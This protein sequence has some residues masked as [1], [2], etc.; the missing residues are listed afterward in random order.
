MASRVSRRVYAPT[1]ED[2]LVDEDLAVRKASTPSKL[3]ERGSFLH[4]APSNPN[5]DAFLEKLLKAGL[6]DDF[7]PYRHQVEGLK[8]MLEQEERTMPLKG[9]IL[10]DDMGLGKTLQ[11]VCL[12]LLQ[13]AKSSVGA[14]NCGGTLI[15]YPKSVLHVWQKALGAD[16]EAEAYVR[17][18]TFRVHEWMGASR[19]QSEEELLRYDVVIT[20]YETYRSNQKG[21][22]I[23]GAAGRV[24]WSRVVLDEATK[25]KNQK[26]ATFQAAAA[27]KATF[28]W[29]LTAT[30]I[31]NSVE[32]FV[33]LLSF[34]KY[35]P[36]PKR[37]PLLRE[38]GSAKTTAEDFEDR[39]FAAA[40]KTVLR[41]T[42]LRRTKEAQLTSLGVKDVI[43][44]RLA[45]SAS[46]RAFY[47]SVKER[48]LA[49]DCGNHLVTMLRLRQAANA[50]QLAKRKESVTRGGKSSGHRGGPTKSTDG[51]DAETT[52]HISSSKIDRL[53]HHLRATLAHPDAKVVIFSSFT[54]ML[55]VLE[56]TLESESV[57][58][59]RLDGTMSTTERQAAIARYET[60]NSADGDSGVPVFLVSLKAGGTGLT[61]LGG[62]R[63]GPRLVILFDHWWNPAA[64]AQAID[65][66]HRIGQK[67]QV[68]VIRFVMEDTIEEAQVSKK[69]DKSL[70]FRAVF[71]P[72]ED[73]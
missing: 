7:Q 71:G 55:D 42:T 73:S 6:R 67:N 52:G 30:P 68:K 5:N 24:L 12:L 15:L 56:R 57:R 33:S 14:S 4:N 35:Q 8:W 9:G 61:L 41:A 16:K 3:Q 49:G 40:W 48:G 29:A 32:D 27:I 36:E 38:L 64:E 65:R 10:A 28:R 20:T 18:G 58:F 69:D 37:F 11:V 19:T 53:M 25:I 44:E 62:P 60:P 70:L 51:A 26:T 22:G 46:E 2:W 34:L 21:T 39:D 17:K 72:I 50:P 31:E 66:V 47:E 13:G 43:V 1:Q 54:G 23:G 45:M 59:A 63:A